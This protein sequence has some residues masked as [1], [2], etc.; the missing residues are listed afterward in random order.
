MAILLPTESLK[1]SDRSSIGNVKG[2]ST[3]LQG[4]AVDARIPFL[5][6]PNQ[7]STRV[8]PLVNAIEAFQ[9]RVRQRKLEGLQNEAKN[10]FTEQANKLLVDYRE[11]K[12]KGAI[13]GIDDYNNQLDELKKQYSDIFKN[14]RDFKDSTDKWL[15]NQTTS[16]KS[17]GYD[18]YSN[19]VFKQN[20]VELQARITNT[21]IAFQNNATSPQ[22]QKF[23]EE[24]QEANRNY[25]QFNGFDL[26]SEEA[27]VFLTKANDEAITQ[28][29][30]Y[31]CNAEQYGIARNRL[32]TFKNSINGTTY[33]DLL[34]KIKDG[35]E[36]QAKQREYEASLRQPNVNLK[37]MSAEELVAYQQEREHFYTDRMQQALKNPKSEEYEYFSKMTDNQKIEYIRT[38]ASK[39]VLN[40]QNALYAVNKETVDISNYLQS[41]YGSMGDKLLTVTADNA[42]SMLDENTIQSMLPRFNSDYGRLKNFVLH[43]IDN[44]RGNAGAD[45]IP[46]LKSLDKRTLY[47]TVHD[48][49]KMAKLPIRFQDQA[50]FDKLKLQSE[51]DYLKGNLD[52]QDS[53]TKILIKNKIKDE[54]NVDYTTTADV[55]MQ[56][57]GA[58]VNTEINKRAYLYSQ[59]TG[60]QLT[61]A[62]EYSVAT[63]YFLSTDFKTLS[64]QAKKTQEKI[65]DAYDILDDKDLIKDDFTKDDVHGWL[66]TQ[67]AQY[68]RQYGYSPSLNELVN[69]A[70]LNNDNYLSDTSRKLKDIVLEKEKKDKEKKQERMANGYSS[71]YFK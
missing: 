15:D 17:T 71:A 8:L 18:H 1:L 61:P 14:H 6:K 68:Q 24:Y 23:Y 5:V 32:E 30:N 50:E 49:V 28:L 46:Y 21:N 38:N 4:Q 25:L 42:L 52:T 16:Y 19:E 58:Q 27:Q 53:S 39:D 51:Q 31:N 55:G 26:D 43:E 9:D 33:R 29:V 66:Y 60:K 62:D 41:F 40:K 13:N 22:A 57:F 70:I 36:K 63:S 47:Y 65:E 20:N 2:S 3:R 64:K 59:K 56:N 45:T 11:Q 54:F 12:L 67:D 10:S 44:L 7:L 34:L 69:F 37:P 35:L 48:N